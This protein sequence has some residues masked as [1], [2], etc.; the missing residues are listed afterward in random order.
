MGGSGES[1][2]VRAQTRILSTALTHRAER[3]LASAQGMEEDLYRKVCKKYGET[4]VPVGGT[5]M[6]TAG[7]SAGSWCLLV[8]HEPSG[9]CRHSSQCVQAYCLEL[10]AEPR[11]FDRS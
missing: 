7:D 8:T 4:P 10:L 9:S 1:R 3:C 2:G 6:Q 11:V 5:S